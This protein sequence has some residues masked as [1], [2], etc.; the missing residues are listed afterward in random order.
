MIWKEDDLI[1]I[2]KSDS[3]I[4]KNYENNSYF[5]DLQKETRLE[6]IVL[7]IKENNFDL[8]K[9]QYSIDNKNFKY[10][11]KKYLKLHENNV[12]LVLYEEI[13]IRYLKINIRRILD[14]KLLIRRYKGLFIASAVS[15][16]GDRFIAL[17]N[18][19][20]LSQ[21]SGFKYGF[22][23][24]AANHYGGRSIESED[25][26]FSR[27]YLEKYSYTKQPN[28]QFKIG[29]IPKCFHFNEIFNKPFSENFGFY[30]SHANLTW[31]IKDISKSYLLEYPKLWHSIGF[32][33]HIRK[34]IKQS[35]DVFSAKF[36]SS[37]ICIHIRSGDIVYGDSRDHAF[38]YH[39]KATPVEIA[40]E[41]IE[42]N[43]NL[44]ILIAGEDEDIIFKLI[45]YI[46][47]KYQKDNIWNLKSLIPCNIKNRTDLDFFELT[48]MSNCKEIYSYSGFARLASM[49]GNGVESKRWTNIFTH[50]EIIRTINKNNF[51]N[52]SNYQKAY[53][54]YVMF[55]YAKLLKKDIKILINILTKAFE[56][57][58]Q[59][60]LF[61]LLLSECYIKNNTYE[62]AENMILKNYSTRLLFILKLYKDNWYF[63]LDV[64]EKYILKFPY[65]C[66]FFAIKCYFRSDFKN[67]LYYVFHSNILNN[68]FFVD[69]LNNIYNP[70]NN[71]TIMGNLTQ[72]NQTQSKLSFQT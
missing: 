31:H 60:K 52:S 27:E 12:I 11:D 14:F 42:R 13:P 21:R 49:I 61:V 33:N 59:N 67:F 6:C 32:S 62:K 2:L 25:Y 28:V 8:E 70:K 56:Y 71:S 51:I 55:Y 38:L 45:E 26:V 64:D 20:Y 65:L 30:T 39:A 23:W 48:F 43:I 44:N 17:L 22:A 57:D 46:Q 5:F 40:L 34:I 9:I 3:S 53:S 1:D 47:R 50:D 41:I 16:Y 18:A 66:S 54:L 29:F 24:K 58:S 35:Q 72:L 37:V 7:K 69:F 19:I 10:F 15:G 68:Q 4:Y 63:D 36:N